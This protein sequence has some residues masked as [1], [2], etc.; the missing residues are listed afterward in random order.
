[1]DTI[2][3]LMVETQLPEDELL[4]YHKGEEADPFQKNLL[5]E[6]LLFL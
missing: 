4:Q 5:F 6:R 3:E 2:A 1:M